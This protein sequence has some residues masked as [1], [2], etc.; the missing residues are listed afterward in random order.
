MGARTVRSLTFAVIVMSASVLPA[1]PAWAWFSSS[2]R[3]VASGVT[4]SIPRPTAVTAAQT[5]E[6]VVRVTWS[7]GSTALA[8]TQYVHRITANGTSIACSLDASA[9]SCDDV[10][11]A[12]GSTKYAVVNAYRTW[13]STSDPSPTITVADR[14]PTVVSFVRS[15]ASPTNATSVEWT[16]TLSEPVTGLSSTN[17]LVNATGPVGASITSVTGSGATWS[18]TA[19]TGTGSGTL[20]L[21]LTS[22]AGVADSTGNPVTVPVASET[23]SVRPFLPTAFTLANGGSNNRIDSGDMIAITFSTAIDQPTL[24]ASWSGAG[25][26]SASDAVVTVVDGGANNDSITFALASCP[27]LHLGTIALGTNGYVAG[28]SAVFSATIT[29]SATT[30]TITVTFRTKSGAGTIG[31]AGGSPVATFTADPAMFGTAGVSAAT[32]ITSTGRF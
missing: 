18:V 3:G 10:G 1:A 24:C 2:G 11:V 29:Y 26:H 17:F 14:A 28:G 22:S 15:G 20:G 23:Y 6:G 13:T 19:A 27:A 30:R 4:A 5:G 7:E 16:L 25:D 12:A 31:T 32:S 9:R 21:T 8:V